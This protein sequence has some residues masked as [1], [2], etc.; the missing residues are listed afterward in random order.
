MKVLKNLPP[1][2]TQGFHKNH[3]GNDICGWNP[4]GYND[5]D[6]IVAIADGK[7]TQVIN[8]CNVNTSGESK[9]G[10]TY[11]DYNNVGN[12]VVIEHAN[13]YKTRYLH[14]KYNSVKVKVGDQVKANQEIGYMG[15]TGYSKGGHLHLDLYLNGTKI[16]PYDFVFKGKEFVTLP[17]PVDRD[18][19]TTQIKVVETRLHCRTG[20]STKDNIIGFCPTG[21]YNILYHYNDGTYDWYEIESGKWI[22]TEGTWAVVLNAVIE[23]PQESQNND[24]IEPI[25]E[26][27]PI[28]PT[29]PKD[30]DNKENGQDTD[31]YNDKDKSNCLLWLV[32]A[33][34]E[35]F[36][37]VFTGK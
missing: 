34:L 27:S 5:F 18:E 21:I 20:H 8:N 11:V 37:K 12:M 31:Y 23:E 9:Y 7:V 6:T 19:T 17:K 15:N 26:D 29:E 3:T 16:D 13:G 2:L 30:D 22:A 25:S 36:R 1:N 32:Q 24:D 4:K 14:L 10:S 33:I 35:F 28:T